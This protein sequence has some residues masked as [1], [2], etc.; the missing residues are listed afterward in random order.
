MM[1]NGP[2]KPKKTEKKEWLRPCYEIREMNDP[3][4]KGRVKKPALKSRTRKA[5]SRRGANLKNA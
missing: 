3:K 4:N 1:E 2:K 5:R